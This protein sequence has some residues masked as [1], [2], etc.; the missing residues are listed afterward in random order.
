MNARQKKF[1]EFYAEC[2]NASEAAR[3][4]GYSERAVR[5]QAAR[6]LSNVDIQAYIAELR[7]KSASARIASISQIRAFWSDVLNDTAAKTSDRL[8]AGELLARSS[9]VFLGV[10]TKPKDGETIAAI[11]EDVVIYL[12]AVQPLEECEVQDNEQS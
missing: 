5:R 4:A 9:G 6:L 8:R 2:G 1:C 3:K 11:R 7:D 10:F 12:P